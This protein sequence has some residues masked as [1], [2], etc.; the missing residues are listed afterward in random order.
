[1][2][3]RVGREAHSAGASLE[4]WVLYADREKTAHVLCPSF[5]NRKGL[6][7]TL[8]L[9]HPLQCFQKLIKEEDPESEIPGHLN[10]ALSKCAH[11]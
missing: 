3:L 4:V 5:P 11:L 8:I 2:F 9:G 1:M 6:S 10:H 7:C